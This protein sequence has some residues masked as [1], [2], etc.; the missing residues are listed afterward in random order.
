MHFFLC[1]GNCGDLFFYLS[2][3]FKV[4]TP[5]TS[6]ET[7]IIVTAVATPLL[8]FTSLSFNFFICHFHLG[9]IKSANILFI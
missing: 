1:S 4:V 7:R 8:P 5:Y 9:P 2:C 3:R 6:W